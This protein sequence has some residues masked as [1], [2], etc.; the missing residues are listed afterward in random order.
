MLLNEVYPTFK[1]YYNSE[2]HRLCDKITDAYLNLLE[3]LSLA[4]TVR[5]KRKYYLNKA[6]GYIQHC[7]ALND[8]SFSQKQISEGF[9]DNVDLKLSEIGRMLSGWIKKS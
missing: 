5:S 3:N 1:N 8:L 6:D 4:N 2:K 9:H 7:K